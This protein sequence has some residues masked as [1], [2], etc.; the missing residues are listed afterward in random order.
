MH[1]LKPAALTAAQSIH[2]MSGTVTCGSAK[3]WLPW[4]IGAGGT[5]YTAGS[6]GV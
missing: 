6:R 2:E 1:T 4:G 3:L 5:W